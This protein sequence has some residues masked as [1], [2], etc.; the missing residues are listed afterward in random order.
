MQAN[1]MCYL[2]E[3]SQPPVCER[4][5]HHHPHLRDGQTKA[6]KGNRGEEGPGMAAVRTTG[7]RSSSLTMKLLLGERR[8][9]RRVGT[10]PLFTPNRSSSEDNWTLRRNI[11]QKGITCF[12]QIRGSRQS[13]PPP[14]PTHPRTTKFVLRRSF[15]LPT[16]T[17]AHN[18]GSGPCALAFFHPEPTASDKKAPQAPGPPTAAS[19][20]RPE[21][22]NTVPFHGSRGSCFPRR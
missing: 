9:G 5:C 16:H 13:A 17:P 2:T 10:P 22:T 8:R 6:Q 1:L 11:R 20:G 4:C 3:S 21:R 12:N 19:P 14:P 7:L 15:V 18:P